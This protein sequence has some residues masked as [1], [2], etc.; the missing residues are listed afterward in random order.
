[1][2]LASDPYTEN[3]R[4]KG[5]GA[6]ISDSAKSDGPVRTFPYVILGLKIAGSEF[7]AP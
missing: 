4:K 3:P 6:F 2:R 7:N 5:G 1:M